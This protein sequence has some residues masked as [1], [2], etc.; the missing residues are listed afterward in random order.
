MIMVWR[1]ARA[2][3]LYS[4]DRFFSRFAVCRGTVFNCSDLARYRKEIV[5]AVCV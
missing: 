2:L 4:A 5:S 3:G 1:N